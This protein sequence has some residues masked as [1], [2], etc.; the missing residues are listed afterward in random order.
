MI[1]FEDWV[2]TGEE[3][4]SLDE[5]AKDR[6][7]SEVA[8]AVSRDGASP[9]PTDAK[10]GALRDDERRQRACTG[11][12]SGRS[13][14]SSS[15]TGSRSTRRTAT[16]RWPRSMPTPTSSRAHCSARGVGAGDG[17]ALLCGNRP[18]FVET[19]ATAQRAGLRLTTIN[20]HLTG[21]EAG[22]IV[23]DCEATAFVADRALRGLRDRRGRARAA[24]EGE[25]RGRRRHPG[26]RALGRCARRARRRRARRSRRSAARCC[27]RRARRAAPRAY[28]G[29]PRAAPPR[30]SRCSS[31]TTARSTSIC[32]PGRCTTPRRSRSRSRD[33][34]RWACR[35]C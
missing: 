25:V 6:Q 21:D 10:S 24:V 7:T 27:T 31:A 15:R 18:E 20:W 11:T 3:Y 29:T 23:D 35:S 33:R 17:I 5:V 12:R 13:G 14:P 32:A 28:A 16:A 9:A 19:S 1:Q 4:D 30:C 22:Y 2:D 8:S 26:I 34:R